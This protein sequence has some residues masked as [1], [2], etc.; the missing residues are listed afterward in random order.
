M[1]YLVLCSFIAILFEKLIHLLRLYYNRKCEDCW[2]FPFNTF[3]LEWSVCVCTR[4]IDS[5]CRASLVAQW[6][7]ICLPMQGTWVQSLV[8]EDPTG[9][10]A[11][12]PVHHNYWARAPRARAPQQEKP[13]QWEA[14][15]P[16]QRVAATRESPRTATK[17]QHSQKYINKIDSTCRWHWH[18]MWHEGNLF[19][20]M[21]LVYTWHPAI[22]W[23]TLFY[24]LYSWN[25]KLG[26][27]KH[28]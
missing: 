24:L 14:H 26:S 15:A 20:D 13:P 1:G 11:T 2:L 4:V 27:Q 25:S 7:R 23:N 12:K 8:R 5:T 21:M 3:T 28:L 19:P 22:F 17:T 18:E 9:H 10:E 6:L 16:Q